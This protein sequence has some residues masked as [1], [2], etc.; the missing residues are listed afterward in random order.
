MEADRS[1]S[2]ADGRRRRSNGYFGAGSGRA[3]GKGRSNGAQVNAINRQGLADRG[4]IR[5]IG[6]LESGVKYNSVVD[7]PDIVG[8]HTRL[9]R[10]YR[11]L[12]GQAGDT[13]GF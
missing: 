11:N 13:V 5:G 7:A 9:R 6:Q 2:A 4:R 8:D 10:E 1:V 12:H 3:V